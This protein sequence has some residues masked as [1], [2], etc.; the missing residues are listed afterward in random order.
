MNIPISQWRPLSV[1]EAVRVFANAPFAWGLAGGY[2]IE[3]FLGRAIRAHDDLDI[4]VFRDDQ[5]RLQ[6]W[7]AGWQ[8]FAADPPGTLRPWLMDEFLPVGIHD[9]WGYRAGATAWEG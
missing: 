9:I 2:A 7:L 3:Q 5:L 1:A 8:L 4:I 6:H